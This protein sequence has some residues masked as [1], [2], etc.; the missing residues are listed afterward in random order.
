MN[1]GPPV[2]AR[3]FLAARPVFAARP[4]LSLVVVALAALISDPG[5][6]AELGPAD[7]AEQWG[8]IG[9]WAMD[10]QQPPA[11]ENAHYSFVRQGP[12]LRVRRDLGFLKDENKVLS[13]G[14]TSDGEIELVTEYKAF[15]RVMTS[16]YLRDGTGQF[17]AVSNKDEKN[18]YAIKEGKQ[19]KTGS[20]APVMSRCPKTD[21]E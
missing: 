17:H 5:S 3:L 19:V 6:G 16:R 1:S 20:P 14:I 13:A 15:S 4:G 9:D 10:C 7:V 11:K 8:L 2:Q 18:E 12:A 21:K